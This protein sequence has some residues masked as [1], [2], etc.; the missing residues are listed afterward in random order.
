MKTSEVEKT[1]FEVDAFGS[2]ESCGEDFI[3]SHGLGDTSKLIELNRI[4]A[5]GDSSS[6]T[7]AMLNLR[8][9]LQ[10]YIYEIDEL[11]ETE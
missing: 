6:W 10:S 5:G 11:L 3:F 8:G 7:K 2:K 1:G 4:V 9:R